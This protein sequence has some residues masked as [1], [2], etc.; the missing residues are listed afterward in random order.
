MTDHT[1]LLASLFLVRVDTGPD[2][3]ASVVQDFSCYTAQQ[4]STN[5]AVPASRHDDQI[6]AVLLGEPDDRLGRVA[7]QFDKFRMDSCQLRSKRRGKVSAKD[8]QIA[9]PLGFS[10]VT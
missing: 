9:V 6:C 3:A 10:P 8:R 2:G 7:P 1:T 4:E 5:R